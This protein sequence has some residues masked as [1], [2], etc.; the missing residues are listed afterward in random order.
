MKE[1]HVC[2]FYNKTQKLWRQ[3]GCKICTDTKFLE[4]QMY[5]T[6]QFPS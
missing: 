4:M 6:L 3:T 2:V 1:S 5:I